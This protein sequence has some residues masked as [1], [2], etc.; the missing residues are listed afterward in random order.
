MKAWTEITLWKRVMGG[1]ALGLIVGLIMRYGLGLET[2]APIADTWLKPFGDSFVRLIKMLVVPL[3]FT[4]LVA[5]VTAMGD[6]KKLGSLGARAIGLYLATTF[7]AVTLGLIMG[8]I[9]QPGNGVEIAADAGAQTEVGSKI[10]AA[11]SADASIA[12]KLLAIIPTNPAEALAQQ[13]VLGIIF[14]SIIFGVGCLMAKDKAAPIQSAI[15]SAAEVMMKVTILVMELAPFGV[16]FLMSWVMA[17]KGIDILFSLGLLTI[18]LYLACAVH[19]FLVY[20]LGIVKGIL[21]LP[22]VRFF[23]GIR[24]AQAVAYST[25]SSAGTL[26]VTI[27]NVSE[28]LGVRK[29]VAASVL[30]VGATVNM[31]GTA[32][33]LG[34][35]ALF[36]AQALGI[37]MTMAMYLSVALGATLTSIGA[38][39]IPSAGLLLAAAVLSSIGV[40]EE[41]SLLIIAM[42]FPFDRLLDMMRTMTNVTGDAAVASAVAKWEGELD[43][44][45][46]RKEPTI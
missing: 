24:D 38:A 34:L 4:T 29:S 7:V 25:A 15:E 5:G 26:P 12:D 37:E 23:G 39:A 45:V 20:G 2:S 42:I 21:G 28:N 6:P 32:I 41:Q 13:D 17:T 19:M 10:S 22:L 1:L 9:F 14:F 27:E 33:Y 46:F 40:T 30:P 36:A 3:I 35:V 16:F 43:E 18:A 44:E 31:D 8:T 11:Q